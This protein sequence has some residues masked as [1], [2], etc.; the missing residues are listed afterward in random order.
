ML[1]VISFSIWVY[2]STNRAFDSIRQHVTQSRV[3]LLLL[4]ADDVFFREV[5]DS[6]NR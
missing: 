6:D 4:V 5:F 3:A 2:Q 1:R